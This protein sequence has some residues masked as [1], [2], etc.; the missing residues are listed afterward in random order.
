MTTDLIMRVIVRT[1]ATTTTTVVGVRSAVTSKEE[2]E[3]GASR[4]VVLIQR[5]ARTAYTRVHTSSRLMK[6]RLW[7]DPWLSLDP[8]AYLLYCVVHRCSYGESLV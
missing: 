3:T 5:R 2:H 1:T 8:R 4:M 6:T 7:F